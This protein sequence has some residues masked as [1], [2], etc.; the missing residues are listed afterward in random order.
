MSSDWTS[1]YLA[2][3]FTVPRP[4]FTFNKLSNII[5]LH[6]SFWDQGSC[7]KISLEIIFLGCVM[8]QYYFNQLKTCSASVRKQLLK[9]LTVVRE[10][11]ISVL[12]FIAI[13]LLHGTFLYFI[14][15]IL[16]SWVCCFII[17]LTSVQD[18]GF[19]WILV[20]HWRFCHNNKKKQWNMSWHIY[21]T[22]Y[23][24]MMQNWCKSIKQF[25][26]MI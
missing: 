5:N 20:V 15:P 25:L 1:S 6:S 8:S 17:N 11:L 9:A 18:E 10:S 23:T 7:L 14:H 19:W 2:K 26:W 3:Y 4:V 16:L 24:G 13:S 22:K 21:K 12:I